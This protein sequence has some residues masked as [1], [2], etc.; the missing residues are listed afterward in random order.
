MVEFAL[1]LPLLMVLLLGVA[2]FGRVFTAE[3]ATEAAARNGAEAAAQQL[4][5]ILRNNPTPTAADYAVIHRL[6]LDEVC[7]EAH[8]LPSYAVDGSGTCTMPITAVCV[9]DVSGGDAAC[10]DGE[11]GVAVPVA[12]TGIFGWSDI[13]DAS[14]LAAPAPAG[15]SPLPYVEVRTCYQFT[16]LFNLQLQLP[17]GFNL[18]LGDIWMQRDRLFVVGNY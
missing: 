10:G 4:Q 14:N 16:T 11:A 2:D 8:V 17:F 13:A 6:A 3:I 1:V 9:H 18:S 7:R 12:C 5:Q 15:E